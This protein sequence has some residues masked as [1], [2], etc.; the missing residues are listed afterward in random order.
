MLLG[1]SVEMPP[2]FGRP[3]EVDTPSARRD[4]RE[5]FLTGSSPAP[6]KARI[7]VG[8]PQ[9]GAVWREHTFGGVKISLDSVHHL[10]LVCVD[11][12]HEVADEA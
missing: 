11:D 5:V 1:R 6:I 3:A 4:E 8:D 7:A 10:G 12:R 9:L 2:R